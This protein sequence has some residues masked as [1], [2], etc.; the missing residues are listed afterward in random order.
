MAMPDRSEKNNENPFVHFAVMLLIGG[1]K[2]H[3]IIQNFKGMSH[4]I[5]HTMY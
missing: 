1:G 3:K 2:S 4:N 5:Y